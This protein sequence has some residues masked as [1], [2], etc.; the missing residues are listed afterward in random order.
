MPWIPDIRNTTEIIHQ[1]AQYS[2]HHNNVTFCCNVPPTAISLLLLPW[3]NTHKDLLF[4]CHFL[5]IAIKVLIF[6]SHWQIV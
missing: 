5:I 1:T 3:Q 6:K 2:C 4:L